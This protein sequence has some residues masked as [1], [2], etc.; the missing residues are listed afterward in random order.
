MSK[1]LP[2]VLSDYDRKTIAI[3]L[4]V[5][6]PG[7]GHILMGYTRN[8][9]IIVVAAVLSGVI[10]PLFVFGFLSPLVRELSLPLEVRSPFLQWLSPLLEE[11]PPL[12][13]QV[14]DLLLN[15]LATIVPVGI[16]I[17][18]IMNLRT[19]VKQ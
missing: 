19:I 3:I 10:F 13:Q 11:L 17:G 16:W 5:F 7:T 4:A 18:Q 15:I 2:N 6:V 9:L 12:P 1:I 8:G 14:L